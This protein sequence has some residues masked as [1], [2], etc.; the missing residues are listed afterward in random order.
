[1]AEVKDTWMHVT[2][3]VDGEI[4]GYPFHFRSAFGGYRLA[5]VERGTDPKALSKNNALVYMQGIGGGT[6]RDA[7]MLILEAGVKLNR[8]LSR[9]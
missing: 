5:I 2:L 4:Y 7:A 8:I 6:Q 9:R 3:L 1:M